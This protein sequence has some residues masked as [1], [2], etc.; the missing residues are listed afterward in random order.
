MSAKQHKLRRAEQRF[1]LKV[2]GHYLVSIHQ[3][4]K[5]RAR[6]LRASRTLIRNSKP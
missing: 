3:S 1:K 2:D 5:Q 6:R 4:Y